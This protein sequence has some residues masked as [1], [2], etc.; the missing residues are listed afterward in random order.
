MPSNSLI[1][2][3]T[4]QLIEL[5]SAP[6]SVNN[7]TPLVSGEN[8]VANATFFVPTSDELGDSWTSLDF[9]DNGWISGKMGVGYGT[10]TGFEENYTT[11]LDPRSVA[12]GATNILMRI[13]FNPGM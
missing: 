2:V 6:I 8:G 11:V 3:S 1:G 12:T 13:P 10:S 7:D 5:V 4:D 9:N